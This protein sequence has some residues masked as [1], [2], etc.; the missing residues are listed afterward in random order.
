M[1]LSLTTSSFDSARWVLVFLLLLLLLSLSSPATALTFQ[2]EPYADECFLLH[3]PNTPPHTPLTLTGDFVLLEKE[4]ISA[5]PVLVYVMDA[6]TEELKYS[7]APGRRRGEFALHNLS[8]RQ[9]YWICVQN[10][11]R[12]P[13]DE[14]APHPDNLAR[15]IGL[16]F[17][18]SQGQSSTNTDPLDPHQQKL[19]TWLTHAA[20]VQREL[21][22]LKDHL[23]Y[24]KRRETDQRALAEKT[25]TEIMTWTL[26][27]AG[28]VCAVALG[29]VL[30]FR[31]FLEKKRYM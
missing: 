15:T 28:A 20:D 22:V 3:T 14:D 5:E 24:H 8:A 13:Q 21:R 9:K 26:W 10:N 18:L 30:Y 12:G 19:A 7:S 1:P 29:Q 27:E 31:T 17:Q 2:I 11:S 6:S 4:Q 25:F 16:S 23:A